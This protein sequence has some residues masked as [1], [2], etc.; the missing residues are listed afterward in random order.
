MEMEC[1]A[2][3]GQEAM[4]G[5]YGSILPVKTAPVFTISVSSFRLSFT[6]E[7]GYLRCPCG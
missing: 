4:G 1:A 7:V 5:M 3:E 6:M 2:E